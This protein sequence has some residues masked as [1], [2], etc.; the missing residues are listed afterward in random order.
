MVCLW[1]SICLTW[2]WSC[3]P[4]VAE[5]AGEV[6]DWLTGPTDLGTVSGHGTGGA[7]ARIRANSTSTCPCW[8]QPINTSSLLRSVQETKS[9][10]ALHSAVARPPYRVDKLSGEQPCLRY[11]AGLLYTRYTHHEPVWHLLFIFF[12]Y[13]LLGTDSL[14]LSE[15]PGRPGDKAQRS[16]VLW[17]LPAHQDACDQMDHNPHGRSHQTK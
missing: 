1:Q 5:A 8:D 4:R 9:W 15:P 2:F 11:L 7:R 12:F 13:S 3:W 14:P 10:F 16:R 17:A 6:E